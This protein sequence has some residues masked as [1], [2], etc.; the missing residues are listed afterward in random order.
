MAG[1]R[2]TPRRGTRA[3]LPGWRRTWLLLGLLISGMWLASVPAAHAQALH[4]SASPSHADRSAIVRFEKGLLSVSA[5]NTSLLEILTEVG[6]ASG[7]EIEVHGI[8]GQNRVSQSFIA[9]PL[10]EGLNEL[11]NGRNY[12]LLYAGRGKD[13]RLT[14]VILSS[15]PSSPAPDASPPPPSA[16]Y[17][18]ETRDTSSPEQPRA[19]R[20]DVEQPRPPVPS[21]Q[22]GTPGSPPNATPGPSPGVAVQPSGT[23]PLQPRSPFPYLNAIQQQNQARQAREKAVAPVVPLENP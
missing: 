22:T 13:K 9:R 12:L 4:E 2:L 23:A 1:H 5:H 14:K 10:A 19:P 16:S 17:S 20:P 11:L 15:G 8:E 21:D 7:V 18:P 3:G 6:R